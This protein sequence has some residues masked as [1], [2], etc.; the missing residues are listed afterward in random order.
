MIEKNIDAR[1]TER[2]IISILFRFNLNGFKTKLGS[3]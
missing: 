1:K 3:F 2:Y